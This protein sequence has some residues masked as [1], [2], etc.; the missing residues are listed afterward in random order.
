MAQAADQH[1]RIRSLNDEL[2]RVRKM[3]GCGINAAIR[4]IEQRLSTGQL[5]LLRREYVNGK[6][7]GYYVINGFKFSINCDLKLDMDHHLRVVPRTFRGGLWLIPGGITTVAN[8]SG[9][10]V[11]TI[12]L[13]ADD[14]EYSVVEA[15][16]AAETAPIQQPE[17]K[18]TLGH[19]RSKVQQTL[20]KAAD[21]TFPKG[22]SKLATAMIIKQASDQPDVKTLKPQPKYDTW[23]R[24]LGRRKG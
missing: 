12:E 17:K 21:E 16:P 20:R 5:L 4:N 7:K 2:H 3:E 14:F 22:W 23:L 19:S 1:T 9:E 6:T 8:I 15:P 13:P 24:A 11:P 18:A 10:I